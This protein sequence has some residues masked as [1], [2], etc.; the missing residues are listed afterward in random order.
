MARHPPLA[1]HEVQRVLQLLAPLSAERRI[2][3]IGG[4][5]VSFW[6]RFLR[7]RS[8]DL[9]VTDPLVSKDID[10]EGSAQAARQ[11]ARLLAG[12]ARIAGI[13]EH[14]PNTGVVLFTDGDGMRR[15]IDFLDA[16]LGLNARDVRDTAV[17]LLLPD[18]R[19]GSET[20]L[21]VMHPERCME[22]RIANTA[23]LGKTT[24]L[25]M[26]QL[27]ASIVCAR[28][29]SRFVLDDEQ[30]PI[31]QRVRAVLKLN[32]RIFRKCL[33]NRHFRDVI[34]G[35]DV[36]PF[37]AVLIDDPRLPD[38]LR[39][40]RYPQMRA[41]LDERFGRDRRSGEPDVAARDNRRPDRGRDR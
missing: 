36:Q 24:P 25:A 10:F 9:A 34:V 20:P 12:E 16:P 39:E 30:L 23:V 2:I 35:H 22:S 13:D 19:E 4:Q 26:A 31:E 6:T 21:W 27:R 11:A 1:D 7:P 37:D 17:R 32:E 29:W 33:T 14:T 41:R 3:L 8:A 15:S 18:E 38:D 5:A 40:R 28:E